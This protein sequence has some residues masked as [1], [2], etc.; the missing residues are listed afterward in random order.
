M[1]N[2]YLS[3]V[4]GISLLLLMIGVALIVLVNVGSVS[5]YL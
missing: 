2:A 4:V 5:R 3:S 1:A